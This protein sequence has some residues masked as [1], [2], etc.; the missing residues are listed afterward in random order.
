MYYQGFKSAINSNH[1]NNNNNNNKFTCRKGLPDASTDLSAL[2]VSTHL[3]LNT[4]YEVGII[5]N[6][7]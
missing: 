3:F 7:L 5:I 6:P 2:Q 1:S 4:F